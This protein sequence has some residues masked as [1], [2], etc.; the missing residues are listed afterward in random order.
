MDGESLLKG[1]SEKIA[2]SSGS[3][4]ASAN[5]EPSYVLQALGVSE[6][7]IHTSIRFGLGR[8]NTDE[9]VDFAVGHVTQVVKDLRKRSPLYEMERS[10]GR[11]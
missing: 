10:T 6:G 5:Q 8:F 1:I 3:A 11:A 9:E 7:L 4:C 2:V